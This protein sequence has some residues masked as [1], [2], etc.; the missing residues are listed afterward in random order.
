MTHSTGKTITKEEIAS[1]Y[2]RIAHKI[3]LDDAFYE[4]CLDMHSAYLGK[5]LDIGCGKGSLLLKLAARRPALDVQLHGVDISPVLCSIARQNVPHAEIIEGDA[6]RL[7]YMS[8]MFDFIFM[9]EAL[10]HMLDYDA[11]VSELVRVLK[12]GGIAVITVPNHDWMSFEFYDRRRNKKRQ[13]VDDHY[14][15]FQEISE[16][17]STHGLTIVNVRGSDNLFY[18]GWKHN[19][20][21]QPLAFFFPFLQKR[22]KRLILKCVKSPDSKSE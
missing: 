17:L 1:G 19:F 21:E 16:I 14:F 6:E 8:E 10:E 9:T 12:S 4:R 13:P 11:A 2:D 22:M 3:G 7:P 18:Y 20:I 5:I 15:R